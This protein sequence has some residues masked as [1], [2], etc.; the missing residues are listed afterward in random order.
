MLVSFISNFNL[1][2]IAPMLLGAPLLFYNLIPGVSEWMSS[3]VGLIIRHTIVILYIL[4]I[5]I[6][7]TCFILIRLELRKP[8][9]DNADA[10]IVLG[11]AVHDDRPSLV[12][13]SRLDAAYE[14]ATKNPNTIVVVSGGKGPSEKITEAQAMLDYLTKKGLP[15]ERILLEDKAESSYQNFKFSKQILD[16][17]LGDNY[18]CIFVTSDFHVFRSRLAA[19]KIGFSQISGLGAP[20]PNWYMLLNFY[21]REALALV[22]YVLF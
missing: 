3:G 9:P 14:Y 8:V 22:S 12:L 2:V 19:Q 11:A 7:L 1:G 16:S 17:L 18:S 13:Q 4:F 20:P 15:K 5:I 10:L 6:F 21:I